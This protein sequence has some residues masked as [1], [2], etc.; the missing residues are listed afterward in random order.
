MILGLLNQV[1]KPGAMNFPGSDY[2][3]LKGGRKVSHRIVDITQY[4]VLTDIKT[5]AFQ[6]PYKIL[7]TRNR[8]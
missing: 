6:F 4:P 3:P 8:I 2:H 1:S 5:F 7:K